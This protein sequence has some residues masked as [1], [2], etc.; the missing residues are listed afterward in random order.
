MRAWNIPLRRLVTVVVSLF[1]IGFACWLS[2]IEN[3]VD[4]LG[5]F[6]PWAVVG[7]LVLLSVNLLLVSFRFWQ[8]L[9]HFGII[10]PWSIALRANV[11][12]NLAGLVVIPLFGQI[13]GRQSVLNSCGIQPVVNA[14]LAAYERTLLA[15]ISG[16]FGMLGAVYLMGESAVAGFLGQI[17]LPEIMIAACG[18]GLLSLW[19]GGSRFEKALS[20]SIFARANLVRVLHIAGLTLAG[21][22][23]IFSCFVVGMLAI[24][25]GLP[26]VSMF[27]AAAVISLAASIPITIGGWGI[28][29]VAAIYVL[30]I[31]GIPVA[32]ALAVSVM[33]GLC[34]MLVILVSAPFCLRK[35]SHAHV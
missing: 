11:A 21:Q 9:A 35:Y 28:R 15:L 23:L 24:S 30:G 20:R 6:P 3:I 18:G 13:A 27:A 29:E 12:G 10:L 1:L 19:L 22:L 2:G 14:G 8:V 34:S 31:L 25:K 26:V 33:V 32:D 7:I 5:K 4:G 16:A 17:A